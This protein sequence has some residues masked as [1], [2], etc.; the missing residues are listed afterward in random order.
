MSSQ[1]QETGKGIKEKQRKRQIEEEETLRGRRD[2][3]EAEVT[4]RCIKEKQ[5]KRQT[6]EKET[7]RGRRDKQRK[8]SQAKA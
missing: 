3:L 2:K 7:S 1:R 8:K 5:E 6:S 4:G